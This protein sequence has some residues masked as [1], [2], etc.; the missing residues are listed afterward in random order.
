MTASAR[1]GPPPLKPFGLVLR[2][3][4]S[5]WHEGVEVTHPRLRQH[6]LRSVEWA[7]AEGTFIV[8]LRHFRGWLDV[9]DTP[10]FVVAYDPPTGEILLTDR[11]RERLR[12]ETLSLDDDDV[13][14]CQVKGRWSA[15]FTQTGQAHLLDAL[16]FDGDRLVLQLGHERVDVPKALA[17]A[18]SG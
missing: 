14:R 7:E 8:R 4:G 3:D 10:Y 17:S 13:L 9:E 1:Q 12:P 6:F 11:S 5:F 2:R 18:A 15:R 16:E